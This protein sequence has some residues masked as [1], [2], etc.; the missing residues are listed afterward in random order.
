MI[1]YW[2]SNLNSREDFSLKVTQIYIYKIWKK[3]FYAVRG[4]LHSFFPSSF[5]EME[6]NQ[7]W[8]NSACSL[9]YRQGRA[10]SGVS[11]TEQN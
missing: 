8:L 7:W 2:S 5:T 10:D 1:P 9:Q 6:Y 4:E 3:F 11:S